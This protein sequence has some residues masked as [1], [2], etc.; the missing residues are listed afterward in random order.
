MK[1]KVFRT[2]LACLAAGMLLAVGG[3]TSAWAATPSPS[4]IVPRPLTPGDKITYNLAAAMEV[5]GGLRTVGVGQPFYL[6]AQV[7]INASNI[8]GVVWSL[9]TKPF[10]S[11]LTNSAVAFTASP[12]GTNVAVYEPGDRGTYK[13]AARTL[14]RPDVTG[15]YVVSAAI[16]TSTGTTNVSI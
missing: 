12:L 15:Q 16:T 5:S 2:M 11:L 3:A 4:Q 9:P 6:E 1:K 10:N 8:V 14:L 7:D 13:V